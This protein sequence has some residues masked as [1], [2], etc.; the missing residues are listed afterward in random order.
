MTFMFI[1]IIHFFLL[2]IIYTIVFFSDKRLKRALEYLHTY[3]KIPQT[4]KI[5]EGD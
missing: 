4:M 2:R 1:I 5:H 3:N